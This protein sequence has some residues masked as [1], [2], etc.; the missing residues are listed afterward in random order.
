MLGPSVG[1]IAGG[2]WRVVGLALVLVLVLLAEVWW[3]IVVFVE[4][5]EVVEFDDEDEAEAF[6]SVLAGVGSVVEEGGTGNTTVGSN[7][8]IRSVIETGLPAEDVGLRNDVLVGEVASSASSREKARIQPGVR[9][10]WSSLS[11]SAYSSFSLCFCCCRANW[12]DRI[13]SDEDLG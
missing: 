3:M 10:R 12:P 2:G 1:C 11:V 4:E 5:D 9:T 13:G 7:G 8:A 6:R